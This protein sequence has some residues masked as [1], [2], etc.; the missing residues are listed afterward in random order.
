MLKLFFTNVHIFYCY[1]LNFDFVTF[2]VIFTPFHSL[3]I[4]FLL[5]YQHFHPIF[6]HSHLY[7]P[8]FPHCWHSN[9]RLHS[10]CCSVSS[11]FSAFCSFYPHFPTFLSLLLCSCVVV[12]TA[13]QLHSTKSEIRFC[14]D[15][16]PTCGVL[17]IYDDEILWQW[18]RLEI[19]L[20][21]FRRS[22]IPQNNLSSSFPIFLS[23]PSSLPSFPIIPLADFL[24]W[25]LKSASFNFITY[26][27]VL[28]EKRY[29]IFHS[30]HKT[31]PTTFPSISWNY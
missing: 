15:W 21:T 16:N 6:S 28:F 8:H 1:H 22:N 12:I 9:L 27:R 23:F 20:N 4:S 11:P 29:K 7:S 5:L 3:Y 13:A 24:F 30:C 17:E 18:P 26:D 2:S 31:N 10:T 14:I 19:R 25:L